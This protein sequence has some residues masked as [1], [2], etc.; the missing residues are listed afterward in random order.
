[1]AE[2]EAEEESKAEAAP[3]PM[4]EA[5]QR[6]RT[7]RRSVRRLGQLVGYSVR[8]AWDADRRLLLLSG[9]LQLLTGL[10]ALAQILII[11]DVL[12]S[13]LKA[14]S[15][16]G[17]IDKTFLPVALLAVVIGLTTVSAAA[18]QQLQRL[19]AELVTQKTWDRILDVSSTVPLRRYDTP[20]FFDQLQRVQTNAIGRPYMLTQ[21][22]VAMAGNVAS[23][24]ALVVAVVALQPVL[25]PLIVVS[26]IPLYLA[27]KRGGNLEFRF[28]VKQT[29]KLRLRTYL[30]T[31]QTGRDEAKELRAFG[32]GPALRSRYTRVYDEYVVALRHHVKR[33]S[34]IAISSGLA[35]AVVLA[36]TMF[37]IIWLVVHHHLSLAAAGAALVAVRALAGQITGLFSSVQQIFESG[38]FM[39]DLDHFVVDEQPEHLARPGREAPTT[40]EELEVT[41]VSFT[42][43]GSSTPALRGV[44]LTLHRG[45][46]VALVGENGSGKTT[47]AKL[48]AGLYEPDEGRI[49]WDGVDV[50]EF[51]QA[52]LRRGIGA[53]FQDFVHYQLSAKANI[54][55]GRPE[56]DEEDPRIAVAAQEA[57]ADRIVT[58]LPEGYDTILSKAFAGGQELSGGQWQRIALARAFYRDASFVILDEP[59][60]AL[61]PR[62]EYE[63]F[64]SLRTLLAGRTV[65]YISHRLST[66]RDADHIYVLSAGQVAEDGTHSELMAQQ[67]RYAELFTLQATAY[68]DPG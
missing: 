68:V 39:E 49:G 42:Y 48:L 64:T 8:I 54:A 18:Q 25:L 44:D 59:S 2:D 46:V 5:A 58:A 66:V 4:L 47:L 10:I 9:V 30:Q 62:A 13:I 61:D 14:Q 50:S 19:L 26:G 40:F 31:V 36:L 22:L 60:A 35:S 52:S 17:R 28:A 41:G 57:G 37:V 55:L 20:G 3:D 32:T 67:G 34:I 38:L 21:A 7:Q 29:P 15:A 33:R 6:A 11:E 43:P 63:L 51:D 56:A 23:S 16:S 45:G 1:M 65:L 12:S 53:I 24:V 27:T